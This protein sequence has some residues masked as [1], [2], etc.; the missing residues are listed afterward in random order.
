M[1]APDKSRRLTLI[2][3]GNAEQDSDVRDFERPLSK[4]GIGEANEMARRFHER[5]PGSRPHPRE[6]RGAHA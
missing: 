5:A 2:R 6:R 3:H 1:T 4:K